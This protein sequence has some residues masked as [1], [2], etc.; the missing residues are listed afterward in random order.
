[1]LADLKPIFSKVLVILIIVV[2]YFTIT[3]YSNIELFEEISEPFENTINNEKTNYL[4]LKETYIKPN[5][6]TLDILYS[7]HVNNEENEENE[8]NEN[9]LSTWK[10][11]TLDQCIDKCN[12]L[13]KCIGFSRDN[14]LDTEPADCHPRINSSQCYSNR[15]GDYKQMSN[16]IKYNTYIKSETPNSINNCIGDIDLT[17]NRVIFLK[18]YSMPN[19]Y[20]GYNNDA[21]VQI[22]EKDTKNFKIKCSFRIEAGKEGSGTVSFLHI[23]TNKYLCRDKNNDLIFKELNKNST[24]NKQRCSF[25]INDGISNGIILKS[26][27]IEGEVVDKYITLTNNYL[28]IISKNNKMELLT[29]YI[30][31]TI[32]NTTIITNK[33]KINSSKNNKISNNKMNTNINEAFTLNLDNNETLPLYNNLFNENKNNNINIDNYLE[34]N[35]LNKNIKNEIL[36][37]TKKLNNNLINKKLTT[38]KNK[39]KNEYNIIKELNKEIEN[40]ISNK[41]VNINKKNTDISN[42]LNKMRIK[43]LAN[44]YFFLKSISK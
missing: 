28:K 24:E 11:K 35:Y 4:K 10:N 6:K 34:D 32:N 37:S 5:T 3:K 16:A 17:L 29:F 27:P 21:R 7:N 31:D 39:N 26:L 8:D 42:N 1:M 2:V 9:K 36:Q 43:D 44:D 22:I 40:E 25:N 38:S 30:V 14:V 33:N 13:D 20:I 41:N 18:T 12:N 23:D 15:K 19:K